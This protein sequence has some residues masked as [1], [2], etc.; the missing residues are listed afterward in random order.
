MR[1]SKIYDFGPYSLNLRSGRVSR[2]RRPVALTN[3]AFASLLAS[4]SG[5]DILVA[6]DELL[7]E[8]WADAFVEEGN[9]SQTIWIVF[10]ALGDDRNGRIYIETVPKYGY[11]FAAEV[12]VTEFDTSSTD[13]ESESFDLPSYGLF[14]SAGGRH[15]EAIRIAQCEAEVY[16]IYILRDKNLGG[17]PF[18]L[19]KNE[20][21]YRKI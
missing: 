13:L 19:G 17:S 15:E 20:D 3:K 16:F 2:N 6:K 12:H 1:F 10:N 14:L 8:V 21:R 4:L 9:I 18:Q 7:R 11:R 5:R